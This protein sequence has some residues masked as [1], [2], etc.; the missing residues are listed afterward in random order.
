[1]YIYVYIYIY[2]N[3]C[4]YIFYRQT[5]NLFL[6]KEDERV[7]THTPKSQDV[8]DVPW[9]CFLKDWVWDD[10]VSRALSLH[11]RPGA[12]IAHPLPPPFLKACWVLIALC[13]FLPLKTMRGKGCICIL[14][15]WGKRVGAWEQRMRRKSLMVF[16]KLHVPW[17]ILGWSVATYVSSGSRIKF[18]SLL[19]PKRDW[20][21]PISLTVLL[22]LLNRR[23]D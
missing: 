20:A 8:E 7:R 6:W 18:F 1:M 5:K 12:V 15:C 22:L 13:P 3:T 10:K 19:L 4:K 23:L 16:R 14:T 11:D 9:W 17:G 2:I 21:L